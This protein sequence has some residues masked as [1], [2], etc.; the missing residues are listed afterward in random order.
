MRNDDFVFLKLFGHN[1]YT[2][3]APQPRTLNA[4]SFPLVTT[5]SIENK[6]Y[7]ILMLNGPMRI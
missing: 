7:P 3:G 1:A 6:D 5:I 2:V 4:V